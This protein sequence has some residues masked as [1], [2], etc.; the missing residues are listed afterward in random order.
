VGAPEY[1]LSNMRHLLVDEI[2]D[3]TKASESMEQTI[4]EACAIV[5][6]LKVENVEDAIPLAIYGFD[7]LTSVR[8]SNILKTYFDTTVTQLQLLSSHM[9]G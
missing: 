6:S 8:L 7:S 3:E 4:R 1:H 5:L 2:S 9:T